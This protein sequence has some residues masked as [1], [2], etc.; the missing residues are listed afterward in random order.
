MHVCTMSIQAAKFVF[1]VSAGRESNM[2]IAQDAPV[3]RRRLRSELRRARATAKLTQKDVAEAMEWSLSKLIRIES[4]L[5]GMST[6]DLKGLLQHYGIVEP[7]EVERF[8]NLNRAGKEQRGWWTGYRDTI[9]QQYL[10]LLSYENSASTIQTFQPLLI[11]GLLQD[12]EY[13]RAVIRTL[14]GSATDKRVEELVELRLRRQEVLFERSNPPEMFFVID[15]AAL[16]RWVGGRDVMRH[17]LHRLKD[18]A[19]RDNVTIEVVPFTAGAHPGML[20]PFVI[21]EFTDERDEDALFLENW[22]GDLVSRDEQEEITPYREAF[23]QLRE[24]AGK[25]DLETAIDRVLSKTS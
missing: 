19:R 7:T 25:E 10:N 16:H 3:N 13:A 11:P 18:E 4:G 22:R 1:V 6:S 20:G 9:S 12:E 21:F 24:L 14:S 15:E 5:V 23:A 8:L 2:T 17:Q